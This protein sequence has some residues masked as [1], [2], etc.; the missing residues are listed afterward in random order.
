METRP[1][2]RNEMSAG[3]PGSETTVMDLAGTVES[4]F[5]PKLASFLTSVRKVPKNIKVMMFLSLSTK[6]RKSSTGVISR[7][8]VKEEGNIIFYWLSSLCLDTNFMY[9]P[10]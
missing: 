5:G 7:I 2:E 4:S 3:E 9:D 8:L 1:G 10:V 6:K